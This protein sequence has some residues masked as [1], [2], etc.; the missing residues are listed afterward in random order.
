MYLVS[1]LVSF[2][3]TLLR[4]PF[5]VHLGLIAASFCLA[6]VI[7]WISFP[8]TTLDFFWL[9]PLTLAC[10]LFRWRGGFLCLVLIAVPASVRYVIAFG[11]TFWSAGWGSFIMSRLIG[12]LII[13]LIISSLRRLT[14]ALLDA[15]SAYQHA[16]GLNEMKDQM[17]RSLNHELRTPLT[18]IQGYLELLSVYHDKL[19]AETQLQYLD[20]ARSACDELLDLISNSLTSALSARNKSN[21]QI[22]TFALRKEIQ[23]VVAHFAPDVLKEHPL[24]LD[25]SETI[26]VQAEPRFVRQI[27]RNLLN[28]AFKYTPP[29][30]PVWVKVRYLQN[31]RTG[32]AQEQPTVCVQIIDTGPGI[33]PEQQPLLFQEF[34]RLPN[35]YTT[36]IPGTG[37]GLAICKKLVEA[38]GG[39][40]WVESNGQP[41]KG[42]CFSFTLLSGRKPDETLAG[43]LAVPLASKEPKAQ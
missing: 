15:R 43:D 16:H 39:Q 42:C 38:M 36:N 40:I 12:A 9:F 2:P 18:Q 30:S 21:L 29:Q 5:R 28:N 13:C 37:L 26:Q 24:H 1:T 11:N 34:V 20:R 23:M 19:D 6:A 14:D 3:L 35:A 10:W 32:R 27:I 25:I 31:Q 7:F 17:L 41:G 22:Q 8:V 4:L 33:P